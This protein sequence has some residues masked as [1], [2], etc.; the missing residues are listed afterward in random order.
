MWE[1]IRANKR[2][3]F[4]LISGMAFVLLALGYVIG[5]AFA[6]DFAYAGLAIAALV[7]G[8]LFLVAMAGGRGILLASAHA[9]EIQ[10]DD[11]PRLFNVVEEMTI[12]AGLGK[13]PKVYI[14]DSDAPN[15]F[16]VGTP[17]NSAVAVTSGLLTKL[18]RDELQGVVAHEIGHIVNQDTVFL[19]HAG[20]MM[21]AIVIIA[22]A[23]VRGMFYSGRGMRRS[24]RDRGGGQAQA[25]MMILALVFAILAPLVAQL[26]YFACSRRREYLAD[27]SAAR[28]TRYPEGLAS[29]L[30]KIALSVGKM[31]D[32]SRAAAP[33]YIVNPLKSSAVRGLFSTHPPTEERIRILRS[34]G[35][36]AGYVQYEKAYGGV[37]GDRL[38]G[39]QTLSDADAPAIRSQSAKPEAQDRA[40][41]REAVDILHRMNGLIFLAC[42]CGLKIKVPAGYKNKKVKCP[43]CGR[44][45]GLPAASLIVA[46]VAAAEAAEADAEIGTRPVPKPAKHGARDTAYRFKPGQWNSFRCMCGGAI[47]LSPSFSAPFVDCPRCGAKIRVHPRA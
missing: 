42:A 43:A 39:E 22:D 44:T 5:F 33:M 38:I 23:F 14:M 24:S 32:V 1:Q 10:H 37:T 21:A 36:G 16:A 19:T 8:M 27:A 18:N 20:V 31:Q 28:F 4:F 45:M 25:L 13:M 12:A 2:R 15:A 11:S 34:V 17:K 40:K 26:L 30:E 46:G 9:R 6:P 3:S 41:A 7:W 29:A 47:Q 35:G